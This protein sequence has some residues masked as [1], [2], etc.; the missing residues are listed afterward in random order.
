MAAAAAAN[1]SGSGDCAV[2]V[3]IWVT[4]VNPL[5]PK[6]CCKV[7]HPVLICASETFEGKVRLNG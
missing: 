4:L 3:K 1:G 5:F 2:L 6:Y 7:T